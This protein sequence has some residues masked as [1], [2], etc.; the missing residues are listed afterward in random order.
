MESCIQFLAEW[1]LS[2]LER[3]LGLCCIYLSTTLLAVQSGRRC[4]LRY[5]G[6]GDCAQAI[7]LINKIKNKPE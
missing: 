7:P 6:Q 5:A 2:C 1:P 3:D 4:P